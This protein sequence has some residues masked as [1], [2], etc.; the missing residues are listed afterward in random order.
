MLEELSKYD[1]Y[2]RKVAFNICKNTDQANDLVQ[3]MYL[4]LYDTNTDIKDLKWYAI[5]TIKN[6]F[7]HSTKQKKFIEL[8]LVENFI[9]DDIDDF[10][11]DDEQLRIINKVK[12]LK[13]VPRNLIKESY[14]K[15]YRQIEE[16]YN[17]NYAYTY[18]ECNKARKEVLG[19]D[20][21]TKY[22]NKRLKWQKQEKRKL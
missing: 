3:E 6:L 12:S 17:I 20:Y 19:E 4:K 2:F 14:D 16:E 13:F 5:V 1:S 22:P 10:E 21:K 15:S 8:D 11:P 9:I 18:R 7:I